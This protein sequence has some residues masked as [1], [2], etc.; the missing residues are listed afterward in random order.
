M[1]T[2]PTELLWYDNCAHW[3]TLIRWLCP[4]SYFDV[5][6]VSNE[7]PWCNGCVE[8]ATLMWCLC[9]LSYFDTITVPTE[10]HW[11]DD[12]AHW[13]TLMW[14]LCQMSYLDGCVADCEYYWE[15]PGDS[16]PRSDWKR[17]DDSGAPIHPRSVRHPEQILQHHSDAAPAYRCHRHCATCL[18]GAGLAARG[19][20]WT[21]G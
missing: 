10:L 11:Y 18:P 20:L 13:V 6:S 5:M 17:Q 7:L 9:P 2:V 8:W 15:Q 12:C 14:S 4:L 16:D 1:I 21:S 19:Y 3:V